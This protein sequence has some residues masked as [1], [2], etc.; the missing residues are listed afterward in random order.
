MLVDP[1]LVLLVRVLVVQLVHGVAVL[2]V[3]HAK[4]WKDI[5]GRLDDDAAWVGNGVGTTCHPLKN[6]K[7]SRLDAGV[8]CFLVIVVVRLPVPVC[9]GLCVG[10]ETRV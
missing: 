7:M 8:P 2:C 3:N 4:G 10:L 9:V 5:R 6:P 1:L